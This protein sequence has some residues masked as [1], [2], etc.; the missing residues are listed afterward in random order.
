MVLGVSADSV[1]TQAKFKQKH[2]LNF[3]LLSDAKK[4]VV[5]TYGVWKQKSFLGKKFMGI[6]RATFVIGPDGTV[7]KIFSKVKPKGHASE[8]LEILSRGH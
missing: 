4:E 3:P 5:Q 1:E 8:I 6:E 2:R 7:R